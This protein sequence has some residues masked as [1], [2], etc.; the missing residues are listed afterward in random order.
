MN[1]GPVSPRTVVMISKDLF[2]I[3]KVKEM[4]AGTGAS[5]TT[6]KNREALEAL[7][8][9]CTGSTIVIVDADKAVLPLSE[10]APLVRPFEAAGATVLTFFSQVNEEV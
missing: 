7:A 4:A 1:S 2:F 9:N 6:A 3:T 10:L 8:A 5:V